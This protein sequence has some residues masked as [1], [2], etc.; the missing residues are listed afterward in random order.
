MLARTRNL[1]AASIKSEFAE[2]DTNDATRLAEIAIEVANIYALREFIER[3]GHHLYSC[4]ILDG[5][6]DPCSCGYNRDLK[7]LNL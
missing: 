3:Y 1:I 7:A 2:I 4:A 5:N 6:G